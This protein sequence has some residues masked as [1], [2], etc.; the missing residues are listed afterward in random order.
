[1]NFILMQV[2][3]PQYH[4]ADALLLGAEFYSKAGAGST[5][6]TLQLLYGILV[7][8]VHFLPE[9]AFHLRCKKKEG[10]MPSAL[11]SHH[12]LRPVLHPSSFLIWQ[13]YTSKTLFARPQLVLEA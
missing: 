1:M 7:C 10:H 9:P 5:V 6:T 12:L 11:S 3:A 4:L 8:K 2:L 13:A